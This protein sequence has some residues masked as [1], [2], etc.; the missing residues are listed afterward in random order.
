M[1]RAFNSRAKSSA[2]PLTPDEECLLGYKFAVGA[3]CYVGCN[4]DMDCALDCFD[5]TLEYFPPGLPGG[6]PPDDVAC[7]D[8]MNECA[9]SAHNWIEANCTRVCPDG[10]TWGDGSECDYCLQGGQC[11]FDSCKTNQCAEPCSLPDMAQASN[12]L[13]FKRAA[14]AAR[15]TFAARYTR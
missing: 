8:C 15:P 11:L 12:R 7:N 3:G 9:D 2:E 10:Y 5:K 13:R 4:G 6:A 14:R 1:L